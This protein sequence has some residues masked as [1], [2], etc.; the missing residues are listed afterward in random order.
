MGWQENVTETETKPTVTGSDWVK[1]I[2]FANKLA[3]LVSHS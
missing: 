3:Y 2:Y 1:I